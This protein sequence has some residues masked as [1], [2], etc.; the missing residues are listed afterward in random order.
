MLYRKYRANPTERNRAVPGTPHAVLV[1]VTPA[2]SHV[3][4]LSLVMLARASQHDSCQSLDLLRTRRASHA[5]CSHSSTW[6]HSMRRARHSTVALGGVGTILAIQHS[7]YHYQVGTL[8][9]S[10]H[11]SYQIQV[12]RCLL[13]STDHTIFTWHSTCCTA[14]TIP[15]SLGTVLA[16]DHS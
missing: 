9:A 2:A 1:P 4:C 14:F 10:Q 3:S 7:S 13:H 11:S 15:H 8:L 5:T 16:W 6:T 12:A